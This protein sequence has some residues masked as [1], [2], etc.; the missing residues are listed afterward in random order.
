[1]TKCMCENC[2]CLVEGTN[3]EWVCDECQKPI[4]EV[5]HC[6]EFYDDLKLEQMEQM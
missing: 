6:P 5:R 2:V 4:E 3:G 1:M